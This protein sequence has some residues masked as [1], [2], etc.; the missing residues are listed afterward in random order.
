MSG[1]NERQDMI[2]EDMTAE[3]RKVDVI[4]KSTG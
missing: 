3:K 1:K 2:L 4:E